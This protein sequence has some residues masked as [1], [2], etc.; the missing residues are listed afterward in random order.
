MRHTAISSGEPF[1]ALPAG[2]P[3][4]SLAPHLRG[5]PSPLRAARGDDAVLANAGA[6]TTHTAACGGVSRESECWREAYDR[7]YLQVGRVLFSHVCPVSDSMISVG[8]RCKH[9]V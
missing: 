9:V 7:V 3:L 4:Q 1:D 6:T 8:S 2:G 5:A